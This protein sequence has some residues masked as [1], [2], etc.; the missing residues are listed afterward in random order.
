[1]SGVVVVEHDNGNVSVG[2]ESDGVFIPVAGIQAHRIE[3]YKERARD[4]GERLKDESDEAAAAAVA[5]L[6]IAVPSQ[7][8]KRKSGGSK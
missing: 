8:S 3:H 7:S 1:M 2:F 6:P 5:E 4:L